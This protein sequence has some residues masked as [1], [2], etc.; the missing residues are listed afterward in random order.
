MQERLALYPNTY[1]ERNTAGA[2]TPFTLTAKVRSAL[3]LW[4]SGFLSENT[5]RAY[6]CEISAFAAFAGRENTAE[7]VAHFL[8]LEDGQAHAVADAWRAKKLDGGLSPASI[9][10]SMSALN[11]LVASARRHGLT[12][13]RLEAK[14]VKSKPYRDTKGPGLRGVQT[15]LAAADR[16]RPEKAARDAAIIR[17]AYGLGLRRGEIASLNIGHCDRMGGTL[18]V[19]GKGRGEREAMTIPANVKQ[20]L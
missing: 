16:K 10:R 17:L 5:R 6:A 2:V 7:A 4:L 1:P 9:N 3:H 15:I 14:G 19:L 18:H 20:A 8:A 13:L 11:S 12:V